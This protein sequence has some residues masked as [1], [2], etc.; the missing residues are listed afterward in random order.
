VTFTDPGHPG[1]RQAGALRRRADPARRRPRRRRQRLRHAALLPGRPLPAAPLA[2]LAPAGGS[3]AGVG[4]AGMPPRSARATL[5]PRH[6]R[7]AITEQGCADVAA[8]KACTR[9]GTTCGSCVPLLKQLLAQSGVAQPRPLRALRLQPPGA[10]RPHAGTRHHHVLAPGREHGRGP[11]AATSAS[12]WW[13][14]SWPAPAGGT[15][16]DGEQATLQDTNDHFLANM[17]AQRHLL[18]GAPDPGGEITPEKLIV[19]GEVAATS[20]L[21]ED[22]RG[23]RIDL[24][25]RGSS[26]C[27][28]SGAGWSTPASSPG[29]RTARRCVPSSPASAPPGADTGC[30]TRSASAVELELRY[31]DCEPRTR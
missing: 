19:I 28:R 8:V 23:Q 10:V 14:R 17:P 11:R 2:L 18:G 26:S 29:T 20:P 6:D 27:R 25:A 22:H 24:L 5:S 15:S 7:S 4:L 13:P 16:S 3:G 21:H 9:A 12:R 30:R 1:L 31:R